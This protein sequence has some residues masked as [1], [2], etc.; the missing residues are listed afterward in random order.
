MG[1]SRTNK[2]LTLSALLLALCGVDTAGDARDIGELSCS[3]H[4]SR[5]GVHHPP[6][7]RLSLSLF[8]GTGV[9]RIW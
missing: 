3:Q 4:S 8:R 5:Y 9:F 7:L 6:G 1:K 2:K